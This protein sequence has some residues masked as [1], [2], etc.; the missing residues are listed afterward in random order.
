MP[1]LPDPPRVFKPEM[2]ARFDGSPSKVSYFL[3]A[4]ESFFNQWGHQFRCQAEAIEF[5]ADCLEGQAANWYMDLYHLNAPELQSID[6]FFL[7]FR[8]RFGDLSL[9]ENTRINL[10]Q[11]KQGT[12]TACE[13]SA[14]FRTL[15]GKLPEWPKSLLMDYYC[16]GLNIEIMGKAIEHANPQSLVERIQGA[17]EVEAQ[18]RLIHSLKQAR[19]PATISAS[20]KAPAPQVV[21]HLATPPN[22][23]ASREQH[24]KMG[25]CLTCGGMGHFA[26][27]CPLPAMGGPTAVAVKKPTIS[28][29]AKAPVLKQGKKTAKSVLV[30]LLGAAGMEELGA[31]EDPHPLGNE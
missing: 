30:N 4:T 2:E 27:Q 16:E 5:V 19:A 20:V 11:L 29:P 9:K 13:Y 14:A 31:A 15:A 1:L 21:C 17:L 6:L 26:T 24:F 25:R 10:K 23:E 3:V 12:M 8:T 18:I 28:P 22:P 7:A